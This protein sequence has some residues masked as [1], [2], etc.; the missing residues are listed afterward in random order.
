MS[1]FVQLL[2]VYDLQT[3][4]NLQ[5]ISSSAKVDLILDSTPGRLYILLSLSQTCNPLNLL[6]LNILQ[7]PHTFLLCW[8]TRTH[9]HLVRCWW[10]TWGTL[11]Y[12][13]KRNSC[14]N[15]VLLIHLSLNFA[16]NETVH[17]K[18]PVLRGN[19]KCYLVLQE[20]SIHVQS[21][22]TSVNC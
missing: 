21:I 14:L 7:F 15:C 20:G 1:T 19:C 8:Y 5:K 12:Y 11:L 13:I 9:I 18:N 22:N 2:H 17:K 10:Y 16:L 4:F 6:I 3:I